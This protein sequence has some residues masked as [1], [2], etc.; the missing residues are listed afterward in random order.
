MLT[1]VTIAAQ[2]NRA[3]PSGRLSRRP[4]GA[5]FSTAMTAPSTSMYPTFPG[6]D[7]KHQQHNSPAASDAKSAVMPAEQERIPLWP[8]AVPILSHEAERRAA[9]VETA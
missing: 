3:N 1:A 7:D 6:A 5:F 2:L 4:Q 9:A 8:A